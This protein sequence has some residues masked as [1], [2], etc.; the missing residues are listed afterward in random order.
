VNIERNLV[1]SQ[2]ARVHTRRAERICIT[3]YMAKIFQVFTARIIRIVVAW[4]LTPY[5]EL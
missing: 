2:L 1:Y 4:V 5:N 3:N